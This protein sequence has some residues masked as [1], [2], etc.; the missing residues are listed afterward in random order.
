MCGHCRVPSVPASFSEHSVC[1][2]WEDK[3]EVKVALALGSQV[4][5]QWPTVKA[6]GQIKEAQGPAN[7]KV[8][9]KGAHFGSCV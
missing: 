5:V 3:S 1:T 4:C 9:R 8:T 2:D 7:V 6:T